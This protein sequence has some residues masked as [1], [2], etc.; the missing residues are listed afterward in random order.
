MW[1]KQC[2][3]CINYHFKECHQEKKVFSILCSIALFVYHSIRADIWQTMY[4]C[5]AGAAGKLCLS[6]HWHHLTGCR[7]CF[8][9]LERWKWL[10][11]CVGR[12]TAS[13]LGSTENISTFQSI[14]IVLGLSAIHGSCLEWNKPVWVGVRP[15]LLLLLKHFLR[16]L[17]L[18]TMHHFLF[19]CPKYNQER[20]TLINQLGRSA[21]SLPFLLT[22]PIAIPCLVKYVNA[23][24]SGKAK[25][26]WIDLF[27]LWT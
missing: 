1:L 17:S 27:H 5:W 20:H 18:S 12:N 9:N 22:S 8:T 6:E 19:D 7:Y 14:N 2:I 15:C 26:T 13:A 23:T 4:E 16:S 3:K 11:V 21:T 25:K 24:A 10:S